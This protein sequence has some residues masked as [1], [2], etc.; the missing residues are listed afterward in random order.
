MIELTSVRGTSYETK[1]FHWFRIGRDYRYVV[2]GPVI[3][4]F[5]PIMTTRYD[6]VLHEQGCKLPILI[7]IDSL[8]THHS[9]G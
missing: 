2:L 1:Q 6:D 3:G 9:T 8:V 5:D 7:T 4:K